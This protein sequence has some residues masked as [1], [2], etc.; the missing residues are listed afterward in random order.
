MEKC[1]KCAYPCFTL[2]QIQILYHFYFVS[3]S[4]STSFL[5]R[6]LFLLITEIELEFYGIFR[7]PIFS[8]PLSIQILVSPRF[9]INVKSCNIFEFLHQPQFYA[10]TTA[11]HFFALHSSGSTVCKE[12]VFLQFCQKIQPNIHQIFTQVYSTVF[13][14]PSYMESLI[15][16]LW[17]FTSQDY[18][19][20]QKLHKFFLLLP[21]HFFSLEPSKP[22]LLSLYFT[23]SQ[24]ILSFEDCSFFLPHV[25]PKSY[26]HFRQTQ[27]FLL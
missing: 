9:V 3:H 24:K 10:A 13:I 5:F 18:R 1:T 20:S 14:G 11:Y 12:S 8:S 23:A 15:G 27:L 6:F 26:M 2:Q 22:P 16:F 19:T 4:I 7:T 17:D 25:T 21:S